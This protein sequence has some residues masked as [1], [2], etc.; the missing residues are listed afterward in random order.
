MGLF[1]FHFERSKDISG[2]SG[3]G[4]VAFGVVFDDG[5]VALHWEGEYA[6][7]N[8][9]HS[10]ADLLHI[11]GHEGSTKIVFDDPLPPGFP[12]GTVENDKKN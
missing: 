2:V 9:Y 10:L 6:S 11:H 7:I 4:N 1:K 5:Q 3:T 12:G 8:I